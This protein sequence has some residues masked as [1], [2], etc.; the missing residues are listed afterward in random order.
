MSSLSQA[1][2]PWVGSVS[3]SDQGA[4]IAHTQGADALENFE[5]LKAFLD[6]VNIEDRG[7]T[8]Q[9]YRGLSPHGATLR[10]LSHL[11]RPNYVFAHYIN[12]RIQ[13]RSV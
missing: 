1:D 11:A 4:V 12:R 9:V 5:P 7:C 3:A 13:A 2:G 10:H 8:G 6:D